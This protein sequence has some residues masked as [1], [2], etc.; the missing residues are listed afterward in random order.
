MKPRTLPIETPIDELSEELYYTAAHLQ[1]YPFLETQAAQHEVLILDWTQFMQTEAALMRAIMRAAALMVVADV[2]LDF[3]CAVI[4]GTIR[5]ENGGERKSLIHQRYFGNI[6]PSRFKRPVLGEQLETMRTWIPSLLGPQS[7]PTLQACGGQ[8]IERVAQADAAKAAEVEALRNLADHEIGPRKTFI[9][10]LN[11]VRQALYGQLA[12][13]PHSRPDLGLTPD[14]AHHF[15]L[16]ETRRRKPTITTLERDIARMQGQLQRA[17][18]E[19]ARLVEE[20]EAETRQHEDAELANA[21]AELAAIEQQRVEAAARIAE[22]QGRRTT[23]G[24]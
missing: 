5:V 4:D 7:S 3:L 21:E 13:L 19:L 6:Q 8:L 17:Q 12:E 16:R 15:F 11:A 23:P 18:V 2:Q 14:F 1:A 10:R 9:D 20:A 22:L 24:A